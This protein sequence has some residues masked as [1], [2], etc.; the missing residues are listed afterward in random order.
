MK[1]E[2]ESGGEIKAGGQRCVRVSGEQGPR[3]WRA[4]DK[5]QKES[6]QV[7][8]GE[9]GKKRRMRR[10]RVTRSRS[11]GT[12]ASGCSGSHACRSWR[13]Q[14]NPQMLLSQEDLTVTSSQKEEVIYHRGHKSARLTSPTHS[15]RPNCLPCHPGYPS[16]GCQMQQQ[17]IQWWYT[18]QSRPGYGD[19]LLHVPHNLENL[20]GSTSNTHSNTKTHTCRETEQD[21]LFWTSGRSPTEIFEASLFKTKNKWRSAVWC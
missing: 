9:G 3:E 19:G 11:I 16:R 4:R 20:E 5:W 7:G 1:F 8:G 6:T 12:E 18:G 14:L 13:P 15:S 10:R 2:T 21:F 17:Q